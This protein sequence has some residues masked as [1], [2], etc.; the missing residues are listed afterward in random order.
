[1]ICITGVLKSVFITYLE[2]DEGRRSSLSEVAFAA[3]ENLEAV[4]DGC[5]SIGAV[6]VKEQDGEWAGVS[7]DRGFAVVKRMTRCEAFL[8]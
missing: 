8:Y 6:A 2:A 5:I 7:A 1:M 4:F 3:S